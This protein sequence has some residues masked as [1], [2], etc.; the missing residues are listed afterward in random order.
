MCPEVYN[1][2][3]QSECK[4]VKWHITSIKFKKQQTEYSRNVTGGVVLNKKENLVLI[5]VISFG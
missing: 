1:V 3:F 2:C 5:I 4:G